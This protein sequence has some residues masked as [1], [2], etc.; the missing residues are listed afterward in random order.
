MVTGITADSMRPGVLA[1]GLLADELHSLARELGAVQFPR[2]RH[3]ATAG[4]VADEET[5]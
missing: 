2:G 3:R 4:F 1:F 5:R